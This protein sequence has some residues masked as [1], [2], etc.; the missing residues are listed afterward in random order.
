M[1]PSACAPLLPHQVRVWALESGAYALLRVVPSTMAAQ[2]N[3]FPGSHAGNSGLAP[4]SAPLP[5]SGSQEPADGISVVIEKSCWPGVCSSGSGPQA[6]GWGGED[7]NSGR[8]GV[9]CAGMPLGGAGTAE[10]V[11]WLVVDGDERLLRR[12]K[13]AR[14]KS[15]G[16]A[17]EKIHRSLCH[18]ML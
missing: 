11:P 17:L 10:F 8:Q 5:N 3:P 7:L 13:W 4:S 14:L 18:V 16:R 2:A 6:G 9:E 15:E 12:V 1:S